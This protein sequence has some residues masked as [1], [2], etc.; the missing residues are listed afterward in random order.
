MR[1]F[2]FEKEEYNK[3][4][5]ILPEWKGEK[6]ELEM[7]CGADTMLDILSQGDSEVYITISESEMENTKF[8]LT[9]Q[10]EEADGG[11][12]IMKSDMHEFEVWLCHVVKFIYGYLPEILYCI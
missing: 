10:K 9:F 2:K 4:F 11:L 6:S 5:V 7:V 8:T 1:E 12:Y 3:W